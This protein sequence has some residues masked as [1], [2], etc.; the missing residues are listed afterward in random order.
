MRQIKVFFLLVIAFLKNQAENVC[1]H[2]AI[3]SQ[4]IYQVLPNLPFWV[5]SW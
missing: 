2:C 4:L 1:C 3:Y 5:I